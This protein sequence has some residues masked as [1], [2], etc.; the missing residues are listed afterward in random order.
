MTELN[1]ARA[2]N[3]LATVLGQDLEPDPDNPGGWRIVR[4]VAK[5]RVISTVDR[6]STNSLLTAADGERQDT[7]R[8][9]QT[10]VS[11]MSRSSSSENAE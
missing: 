2:A 8:V 1:D 5:D 3:L 7:S 11:R 4:R 10:G 6:S 9:C